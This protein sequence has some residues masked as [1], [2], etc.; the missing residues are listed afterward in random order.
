[1]KNLLRNY[2]SSKGRVVVQGN[3][4]KDETGLAAIFVDAASSASHI[5]ASKLC[6]ATALLP[7]SG[8]PD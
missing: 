5:E 3:T 7:N 8:R 2:A 4:G 1:M 6:D